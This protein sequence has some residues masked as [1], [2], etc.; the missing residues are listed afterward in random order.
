MRRVLHQLTFAFALTLLFSIAETA[1]QQP[2]AG[3]QKA[4]RLTTDDVRPA[5]E[6]PIVESKDAVK[7]AVKAEGAAKT[8]ESAKADATDQKADQTKTPNT[9]LSPE[10]SAW[11]E[12][13]ATAREKARRLEKASEEAEL[14][15]TALKNDLGVSGQSA[16][17]R[18]DT[19]AELGQA[20][21]RLSALRSEASAAADDADKLTEYGKQKG[22]NEAAEKSA[23]TED[24]KAN[25]DFY[26]TQFVKLSEAL[27]TAQR[28]VQLYENRVRD[29]NQQISSNSGGKDKN[30][31]GTGGDSFYAL[32]LQKDRDAAQQQL[33]DARLSQTKAQNDLDTLREDAR[34]AGVPAGVLR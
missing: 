12:R 32:Q 17:Q 10:E 6:Q 7:D 3:R 25:E 1:A 13:V 5:T 19:A 4:P 8:E 9:K 14:R 21:Q 15:I 30:G 31:R 29:L 23:T 11:R 2:A 33:E 24:G 16:R 18:N 27:E 20:G 28:R 34:R 26:R 22:F